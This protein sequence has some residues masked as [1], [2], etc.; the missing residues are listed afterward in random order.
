MKCSKCGSQYIFY[1]QTGHPDTKGE[2][3]ASCGNCGHKAVVRRWDYITSDSKW[4]DAGTKTTES[5]F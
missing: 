4:S 3:E 5:V 2:E 1:R